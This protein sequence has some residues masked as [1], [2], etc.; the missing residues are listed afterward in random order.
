MIRVEP[1][2][3]TV[4]TKLVTDMAGTSRDGTEILFKPKKNTGLTPTTVFLVK[5]QTT[6]VNDMVSNE[7]AYRYLEMFM[8]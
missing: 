7:Q 2:L 8:Y 3:V 6:S 1:G 5:V 4:E